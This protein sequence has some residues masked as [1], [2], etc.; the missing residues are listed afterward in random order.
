MKKEFLVQEHTVE[1]SGY[2]RGYKTLKVY[3]D[4]ETKEKV[5]W[6]CITELDVTRDDTEY[7]EIPS[8]AE[9][10]QYLVEEE[11]IKGD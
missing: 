8:F 11:E 9:N 4:S 2:V 7:Y 1:F 10:K 6:D 3:Y 5:D